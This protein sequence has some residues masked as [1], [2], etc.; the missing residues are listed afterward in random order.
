MPNNYINNSQ[1]PPNYPNNLPPPPPNYSSNLL[2][3]PTM[4]P[5]YKP[6]QSPILTPNGYPSLSPISSDN[7][8]V[9][10][11]ILGVSL[12]A[13]LKSLKLSNKTISAH[14]Y[15]PQPIQPPEVPKPP[16][17]DMSDGNRIKHYEYKNKTDVYLYI[18]IV[19]TKSTCW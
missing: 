18:Y 7:V 13:G 2:P 17:P 6:S 4:P 12:P 1:F 3:P 15:Q 16:E 11:G 19:F 8:P 9:Q 5:N 14:T 10:T